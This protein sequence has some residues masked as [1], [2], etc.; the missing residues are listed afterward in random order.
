MAKFEM[1][2]NKIFVVKD[3]KKIIHSE[4]GFRGKI[5]IKMEK[6]WFH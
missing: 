2:K 4:E 1:D 6:K 5:Q 3:A